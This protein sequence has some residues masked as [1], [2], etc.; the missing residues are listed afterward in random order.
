MSDH[1]RVSV[2][3]WTPAPPS[4][5]RATAPP[6]LVPEPFDR[7][8][9]WLAIGAAGLSGATAGAV[10]TGWPVADAILP[11]AVGVAVAAAS[12]TA[13]RRAWLLAS[14]LALAFAPAGTTL[15]VGALGLAL[16]FATV[17]LERRDLAAGALV[18]AATVHTAMR[19]GSGGFDGA[20]AIVATVLLG[21]LVI[22]G[23]LNGPR[24]W[25]RRTLVLSAVTMFAAALASAAA[26]LAALGAADTVERGIDQALDGLDAARDGDQEAAIVR[27]AEAERSLD[28]AG[29]RLGAWWV[30]PARAVPVV[31]LHVRAV[32][33][34]VDEGRE[35]A[36]V[37]GS[38]AASATTDDLR[39]AGGA[40]DLGQVAAVR[41]EVQRSEEALRAAAEVADEVDSMWLVS[42]LTDRIERFRDEIDRT[43]PETELASE[44]LEVLPG[45]LG[46][47]GERRYLVA[48]MTPAEA[49]GLNG[50]F[51][52]F[53]ELTAVDGRLELTR[54]GRSLD[55]NDVPNRDTRVISG[56]DD[57]LRRWGA[58]EPAR[59][60]QDVSLSPD[61]PT[62]ATVL[63]ELYPQSGGT[64]VDGVIGLDPVALAAL[65]RLTGP[66]EV[67][68]LEESLTAD[69]AER[70]LLRDQYVLFADANAERIDL[71]DE[72]TRVT[73][74]RLTEVP[75]PG[76]RAIGDALGPP[77]REGRLMVR[78]VDADEN[79]LFDRLGLTNRFPG[80]D[81]A[82]GDFV[83]VVHQNS[84]NN[85]IDIFLHREVDYDVDYDPATGA[86]EATATIRLRNDAPASG[87]P[88][89][90]IGSGDALRDVPTGT[91]VALLSLY[92]P[93]QL[94]SATVDDV[95][96]V[97][98]PATE[99]GWNAYTRRIA[100]PAG[101]TVEIRL[102]LVGTIPTSTYRLT[103][104]GQPVVNPDRVE[105]TVT[106]PDGYRARG[107][108]AMETTERGGAWTL[109]PRGGDES[110]SLTFDRAP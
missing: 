8:V 19:L 46:A 104:A 25:R 79:A 4:A 74:E 3:P 35:L 85:K 60:I 20:T 37:A 40:I 31:G 76:P 83:S 41:T 11:A 94:V 48:F 59:F 17:V 49:R 66:V 75:L 101:T 90:V 63:A 68:G 82:T 23:L 89:S 62:V 87:L 98:A 55:L 80:T 58:F 9:T 52:N 47:D 73:F 32:S 6:G 109:E 18:G 78:T 88:D 86:V 43:L 21:G 50:L 30:A 1:A 51:G 36:S 110:G 100:V 72:A 38:A 44:V 12:R 5:E 39:V 102:D 34:L 16:A 56:P 70:I 69:N 71:L 14:G 103:W 61:F 67:S 29:E 91:N 106:V 15:G 93:H 84:A 77:A 2:R 54:T 81:R 96:A 42:P 95:G 13:S 33:D 45:I 57:Y 53:A 92:T 64:E 65:L 108:I 107:G 27:F 105:V 99:L 97:F 7:A 10:P 28:A 26:L 24:R 22:S